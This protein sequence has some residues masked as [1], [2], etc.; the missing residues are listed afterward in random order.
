MSNNFL[1]FKCECGDLVLDHDIGS[2]LIGTASAD[3]DFDKFHIYKTK[4]VIFPGFNPLNEIDTNFENTHEKLNSNIYDVTSMY[5][6]TSISFIELI[7]YLCLSKDLNGVLLAKILQ[8]LYA[9]KNNHSSLNIH[10]NE[11]YEMYVNWLRSP[12]AAENFWLTCRNKLNQ[13]LVSL[14]DKE[15]NWSQQFNS[16]EEH[17]QARDT[18]SSLKNQWP[19]VD[20]KTGYDPTES[21]IIFSNLLLG[22]SIL[23][24]NKTISTSDLNFLI[25]LR[26]CKINFSQYKSFKKDIW[27]RFFDATGTMNARYFLGDGYSINESKNKNV[28][29]FSGLNNLIE[30]MTEQ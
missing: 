18:W 19:K 2:R 20:K 6:V 26:N 3:S 9:I 4:I 1:H 13:L 12:G 24:D 5:D 10:N 8:H 14:P 22:E 30:K 23:S 11:T 15:Y 21:R 7:E 27:E 25:K 16:S 28:Y 17:I 29:G